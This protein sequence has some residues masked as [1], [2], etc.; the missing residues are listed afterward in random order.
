MITGINHI[1]IATNDVNESFNFYRN[2]LGFKPLCK[3]DK[4]AYFLVGNSWFCINC[5]ENTAPTQDY[6]HIAFDVIQDDFENLK[7]R[8]I[9]SNV[10]IFKDNISEGDSLYFCDPDGHKLEI[11][12]GDWQTRIATKK[13]NPGNWQNVEF[14]I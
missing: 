3:W 13:A 6:T 7:S 5:D 11:H 12:V 2:T 9:A 14:F 10:L 8:I 1:T 4:G